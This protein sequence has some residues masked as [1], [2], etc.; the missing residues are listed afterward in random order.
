MSISTYFNPGC[1]LSSYKPAIEKKIPSFLNL[2]YKETAMHN[3]CYRHEPQSEKGS[4]RM[5]W[6]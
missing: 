6:M 5:C 1:A 2:N 3:I 4:K